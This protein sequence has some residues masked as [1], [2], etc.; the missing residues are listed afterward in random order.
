MRVLIAG[1]TGAV[2]TR[3]VAQLV[4]RGHEVVGTSRSPTSADTLRTL[5]ATPVVLDVLDADATREVVARAEPDAIV[6]EAT[7]LAGKTDYR[8]FDDSFADTNRLRTE[9]T[10]SLLAAARETGVPR[11][12]VQSYAGWPYAREGGPVKSENDPLDTHPLPEMRETLD[13]IEYLEREVLEAGGVVLRYGGLYGAPD[14]PQVELVRKRRFPIVGDGGGVWSFVHL[15]DAATAT[16]L[17]V[18]QG[19]PGVYN[20]VDSDPAPVR[21]W[22]PALAEAI[23][24]KPPYRVPRWLAR[25]LAGEVGVVLMTEIR[26]ASNA[27]AQRDLGWMLRHPSWREGFESAY[28]W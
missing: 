6:H 12:V 7:A 4:E 19:D 20:V 17:A 5:G 18:E 23:H 2:G 27:K 3:L 28:G 26:G 15:D 24:A 25:L 11:V 8:H 14:D 22:L 13:A 10:D 1:A 21:E 16:V 9:G